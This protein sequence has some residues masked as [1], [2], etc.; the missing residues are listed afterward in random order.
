MKP[1]RWTVLL[2]LL[3]CL[4]A[5][6]LVAQNR[7]EIHFPDLP[8]FIT[9]KCDLHVHT[10]FSDGYVWPT[11]RVT[12]AWTEGLDAIAIADHIEYRPHAP[13][14]TSDLN[15][16]WE[17]ARKQAEKYNIIL[18]RGAEI[19]RNMPPGHFNALFLN[20]IHPLA[21]EKFMDAI[22]AAAKQ[23]AFI[24]WNHPGW[25]QGAPD[26]PYW[27][28]MHKEL[29]Q[30]GYM[31]GIE[32][33][34]W[35]WYY[36]EA[37]GYALDSGL[38]MLGNSDIHGPSS[39]MK[40]QD[41]DWHRPVTLV[42]AT[43][44][45]TEGIREALKARRTA[46][47]HKSQLY[48]REEFAAPLVAGALQ[49]VTS[50]VPV[51]ESGRGSLVLRNTSDLELRLVP[52]KSDAPFRISSEVIL[53]PRTTIAVEVS[54]RKNAMAGLTSMTIP[55]SVTNVFTSPE[56]NLKTDLQFRVF[57]IH[58]LSLERKEGKC[59]VTMAAH[60]DVE[61]HLTTSGDIPQRSSGT[62]K[63]PVPDGRSRLLIRAWMGNMPLE[64]LFEKPLWV[65]KGAGLTPVLVNLPE[66]KYSAG[67]VKALCDGVLGTDDFRCGD[68]LGFYKDL[69]ATLRWEEPV[70]ADTIVV[71]CLRDEDSWIFL[72]KSV[73]VE[74]SA[75]GVHYT[76]AKAA[77]KN[78]GGKVTAWVFKTGTR[79]VRSIRVKV[80]SPGPC[81]PGHAGE[82][83]PSWLFVDEIVVF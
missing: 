54:A 12:E 37:F 72:P 24:F 66:E 49:V 21:Q 65:H 7:N 42:F 6:L 35:D 8:G 75:D 79:S 62:L 32:V 29:L 53:P 73:T 13:Y 18:I 71:R 26:T 59:Y 44:R 56:K 48:A 76:A 2:F 14:I 10:C 78:T 70:R 67:G 60:P 30:K 5:G 69:D 64:N 15:A 33:A 3:S 61:L 1:T 16:S 9:L 17:I 4:D 52:D 23:E 57:A 83:D 34:N 11:E 39:E 55:C 27:Y 82:G 51:G 22:E 63:D 80:P 20:D 25:R 38:T 43:S 31:H 28:P 45:T 58:G 50:V 19:T 74:V 40:L 41:P 81:P 46:V 36:P 68:W 77:G 47:W